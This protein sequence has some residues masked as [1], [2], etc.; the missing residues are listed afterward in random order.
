MTHSPPGREPIARAFELLGLMIDLGTAST[1][2][3][4]L[5]AESGMSVSTVHR[6]LV[7]LER[8]SLVQKD[9]S[10]RYTLGLELYRWGRLLAPVFPLREA[11]MPELHRLVAACSETAFLGVYNPRTR[12]MMY[13]ASV[14]SSYALRYVIRLE[15]W[16]PIHAGAS[17][18]AILAFLPPEERR[19]VVE[20]T[21]L[22]KITRNTVTDPVSL[23][24]MLDLVRSEGV[25]VTHGQ[26]IAGA[27]GVAAPIFDATLSVVG[28]VVLTIPEHRY[29]P[30]QEPELRRLVIEAVERLSIS[31]GAPI[32][33]GGEWPPVGS[34]AAT[35]R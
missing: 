10:G 26:N 14:E 30:D 28:D 24:S 2:V 17:G 9:E 6:T 23:T 22:T 18:L 32:T 27:V 1:G 25:A 5:A 16:R 29:D 21:P 7:Q 31:L 3:R 33:P 12:Q 34:N 11:A 13:T 35:H 20:E 8:L 19:I 4:E 15:E